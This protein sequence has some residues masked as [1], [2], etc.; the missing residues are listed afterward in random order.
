MRIT[1]SWTHM[2]SWSSKYWFLYKAFK[3]IETTIAVF[4]GAG[5]KA[6]AHHVTAAAGI[7]VACS[8]SSAV[9]VSECLF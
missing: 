2:C 7:P 9:M 3:G 6:Q 5:L 4:S 1:C 8:S